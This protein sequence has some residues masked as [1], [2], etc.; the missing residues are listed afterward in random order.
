VRQIKE[1]LAAGCP[2]TCPIILAASPPVDMMKTERSGKKAISSA[3]TVDMD[4]ICRTGKWVQNCETWARD[5]LPLEDS[6]Y[7]VT[8]ELAKWLYWI[9]MHHLPPEKRQVQVHKLLVQ[10]VKNKHNGMSD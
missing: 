4:A 9:E 2:A 6:I 7:Q 8:A 5:G 3:R 10:F 1:W